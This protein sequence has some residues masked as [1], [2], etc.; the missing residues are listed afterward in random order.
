MRESKIAVILVAALGISIP[1]WAFGGVYKMKVKPIREDPVREKLPI[2]VTLE[3]KKDLC[4]LV[5]R[6]E[7]GCSPNYALGEAICAY[8][9]RVAGAAFAGFVRT[10]GASPGPVSET[11]AVLR[12]RLA[13]ISE[14][15][16][17]WSWSKVEIVIVIEW[18]ALDRE[19]N[20]L[21]VKTVPGVGRGKQG[22]MFTCGGNHRKIT[23]AA[24][25]D[26]FNQSL[27]ELISSPELRRLAKR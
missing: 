3:L 10:D 14:S 5:K 11:D 20:T 16:H 15:G 6:L 21:W 22:T 4:G 26:V 9:E 1:V 2:R 19:G 24:V 27:N 25:D 23:Q 12:P 8:S 7:G 13:D 17:T 18:A